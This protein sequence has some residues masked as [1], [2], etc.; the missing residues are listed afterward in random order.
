MLRE[1]VRD[2]PALEQKNLEAREQPDEL[3]HEKLGLE[4]PEDELRPG[5]LTQGTLAA[6]SH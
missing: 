2:A 1:L 4:R 5:A 6:V 3:L